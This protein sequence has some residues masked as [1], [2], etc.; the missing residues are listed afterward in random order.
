ME[1]EILNK[2]VKKKFL[3]EL[4]A[5]GI[6]KLDYLLLKVGSRLRIFSGMLSKDELIRLIKTLNVDNLGLYFAS[7]KEGFRLSL[8]AVH[9][10][11]EQIK[12]KILELS[13]EEAEKWFRGINLEISNIPNVNQ[14]EFLILKNKSDFIGI[15]K[16]T[17][18]KILNFLPKERRIR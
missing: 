7:L 3:N 10:L 4:E 15:G 13:D 11:R 8:D 2:A 17:G 5:Y 14:G 1:I 16:F 6:T 9:I 18:S 12:N